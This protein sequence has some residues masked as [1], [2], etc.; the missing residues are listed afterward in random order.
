MTTVED[1][2]CYTDV[3]HVRKLSDMYIGSIQNTRDCRW[4]IKENEDGEEEAIQEELELNPGLEQCILELLVNAA[5]H[6]E[7]CR[8]LGEDSEQVTKVK[9]ELT[10]DMVSVWNNGPG[11]PVQVHKETKLYVPEMIFGNLRSSSNYK[12]GVKKTWGGKNGI[13]AKAANIFSK[14][15]VVEVQTDGKKYYQEWTDG[16]TKKTAAKITKAKGEDYTKISYYPDFPAF[17]MQSFSSNSTNKLIEKRVYDISAATGKETSVWFNDKKVP[18]KDFTDYMKLYIGSAKKVVW[19]TDRWEVGFALC[20]YDQATQI[21][22]V[23]AICTDEGG[24]HV[25]HVLDP[26]LDKITEELQKK[27]KGVTIKKQ[28]IKD[29]VI[30]FIKAL[31]ENPS[32]SSQLKKKLTTTTKLFGSVCKVPEDVIKKVAKLGIT[33]NVLEIA[34]AKDMKTAM[35]KID[36]TKNVRLSEI[37]KLEDANWAGTDKAMDCTLILTEGDSS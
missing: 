22:F 23:N 36:G 29:N 3:E 18:V 2:E 37:K 15:F 31:I 26:V 35:K 16:M 19:K 11:I 32:F 8:T 20:P 9:V 17:G 34:K 10:N 4:L 7:R 21:S 5:D 24:T 6:V 13:G 25:T 1:F 12:A 33:D 27:C 28:Y 30:I 14:R